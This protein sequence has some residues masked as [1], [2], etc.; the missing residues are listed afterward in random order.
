MQQ[1]K[2]RHLEV[3][4]HS[5][6][7]TAQSISDATLREL[8]T[9]GAAIVTLSTPASCMTSVAPVAGSLRKLNASGRD[10][11]IDD[12]GLARAV[13]LVELDASCNQNIRTVATFAASLRRID[14]SYTCGIDDAGLADATCIVELKAA[15]NPRISTVAP[16]A[17]S[18]RRLVVSD[19]GIDDAGL[20]QAT[21]VLVQRQESR[22]SPRRDR[23]QPHS[24]LGALVSCFAAMVEAA[25]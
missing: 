22:S 17:A 7:A 14:A 12:A 8:A 10:C 21:R 1:C 23:D 6:N 4:P 13:R 11:G 18:L 3:R 2:L 24:A 9:H 5:S 19:C 20:A 25:L 15:G 16:F